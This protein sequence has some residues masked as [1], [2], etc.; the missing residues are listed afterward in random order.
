[1]GND[2]EN[3]ESKSA[4]RFVKNLPLIIVLFVIFAFG[5]AVLLLSRFS[6]GF[7]EDNVFKLICGLVS[8]AFIS[9]ITFLWAEKVKDIDPQQIKKEIAVRFKIIESLN[10]KAEKERKVQLK[11]INSIGEEKSTDLNQ[12]KKKVTKR[13]KIIVSIC[14]KTIKKMER[15]SK[16]IDSLIKKLDKKFKTKIYE[17]E[18]AKGKLIKEC[19]DAYQNKFMRADKREKKDD[20][21]AISEL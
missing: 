6:Y 20:N 3:R 16:A 10:E 17:S 9:F 13:Y 15:Q 2:T 21:V 11:I 12:I 7:L 19:L 4:R 1:M 18:E 14:E 8:F 5:F